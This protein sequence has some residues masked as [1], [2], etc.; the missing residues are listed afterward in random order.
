MLYTDMFDINT[1]SLSDMLKIEVSDYNHFIL[2]KH[3]VVLIPAY[4]GVLVFIHKNLNMFILIV[5][6]LITS[7]CS[8]QTIS[9]NCKWASHVTVLHT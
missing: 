5:L 4:K 9:P 7:K 3:F 1:S 6:Q 8:Q 2:V